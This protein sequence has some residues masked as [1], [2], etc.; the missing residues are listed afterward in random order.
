MSSELLCTRWNG[1]QITVKWSGN[2]CAETAYPLQSTRSHILEIQ[3]HTPQGFRANAES[4]PLPAIA[5]S[6]HKCRRAAGCGRALIGGRSG[7]S[8]P[9]RV[10][11]HRAPTAGMVPS[12]RTVH[13]SPPSARRRIRCT[14]RRWQPGTG[15]RA[16]FRQPPDWRSSAVDCLRPNRRSLQ[17][18]TWPPFIPTRWIRGKAGPACWQWRFESAVCAISTT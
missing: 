7:L 16:N 14:A 8:D 18:T 2:D 15:S 10:R 13:F 11:S 3:L 1:R 5:R 9:D 12:I 4:I 17:S 6:E